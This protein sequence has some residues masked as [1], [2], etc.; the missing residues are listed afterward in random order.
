MLSQFYFLISP[1]CSKCNTVLVPCSSLQHSFPQSGEEQEQAATW[2]LNILNRKCYQ[3][4]KSRQITPRDLQVESL[5]WL[6]IKNVSVCFSI[7]CFSH[8]SLFNLWGSCTHCITQVWQWQSRVKRFL[9]SSSIVCKFRV[10]GGNT[11]PEPRSREFPA[12]KHGKCR[13]ER[14]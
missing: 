12:L 1:A 2:K 8:Y 9:N 13:A 3:R 4:G 11:W 6:T 5:L 10:I 14:K 7:V